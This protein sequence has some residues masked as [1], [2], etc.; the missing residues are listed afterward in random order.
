MKVVSGSLKGKSLKTLKGLD[1]RPTPNKVKEA[2]FN[3]L[4]DK[5]VDA[6]FG[7]C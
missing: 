2:L 6:R 5:I 7:G 4:G 3:I 1:I